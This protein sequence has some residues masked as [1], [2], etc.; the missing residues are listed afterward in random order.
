MAIYEKF[1][2]LLI[3]PFMGAVFFIST[4]PDQYFIEREISTLLNV[5]I[6]FIILS[7]WIFKMSIATET[8]MQR[9][10]CNTIL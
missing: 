9:I 10:I 7:N 8:E 6:I 4:S 5:N 1:L 2:Q 3:M